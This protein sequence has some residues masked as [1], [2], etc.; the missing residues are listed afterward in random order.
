MEFTV[1]DSGKRESFATGAVRDTEDGKPRIDLILKWLPIEALERIARHYEAGAAKYGPD[2][3]KQGIP[4]S[5][6]L[7]SALRHLYQYSRGE[8]DEDHLAATAFNVLAIL[9]FQAKGLQGGEGAFDSRCVNRKCGTEFSWR[10]SAQDKEPRPCY[11]L[12]VEKGHCPACN[13]HTYSDLVQKEYEKH[14][15]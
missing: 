13:D 5:R 11:G 8:R 2:N 9:Y 6:C 3:W 10:S 4:E 15:A 7:S 12:G 1:K 14:H